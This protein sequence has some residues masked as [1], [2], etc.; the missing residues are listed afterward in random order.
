MKAEMIEKV[1]SAGY[2]E[3]QRK[4]VLAHEAEYERAHS[5]TRVIMAG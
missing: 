5:E 3:A 4:I 1:R 2:V